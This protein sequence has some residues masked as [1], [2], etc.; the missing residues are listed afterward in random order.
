MRIAAVVAMSENHIIGYRNSLPWHLPADLK[1]FKAITMD[2]PV[3]M[4]RKTHESI[5][6]PLP[7]RCNI[8]ITRDPSFQPPGCV[9]VNSIEAAL[10]A[11]S[12][13]EEVLIIGG[14]L[15]FEHMLP[16]TQR[17]YM[18]IIHHDFE[19]DTRF[20]VLDMTQWQERN[21]E[22]HQADEKNPYAYTFITYER[23]AS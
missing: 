2:K 11:A 16:R 17:I 20:P 14:A 22:A 15:L 18:T 13:S 8:V 4:G 23:I 9:V 5:G 12:Y 7:G 10:E 21:R 3:I 6:K 19:G 1:H